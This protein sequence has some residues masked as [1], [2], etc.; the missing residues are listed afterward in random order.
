MIEGIPSRINAPAADIANEHDAVQAHVQALRPSVDALLERFAQR[1]AST[2]AAAAAAANQAD[3][4][5][6][7][8]AEG[9]DILTPFR[10]LYMQ[11]D[12]TSD[13]IIERTIVESVLERS[14][15]ALISA[16]VRLIDQLYLEA[17]LEIDERHARWLAH[18]ANSMEHTA[19]KESSIEALLGLLTRLVAHGTLNLQ[20][21]MDTFLL[22][23]LLSSVRRMTDPATRGADTAY[24]LVAIVGSLKDMF[25][26]SI[27]GD[28]SAVAT[29]SYEDMRAFG[30]QTMLLFAQVNLPSLLR[31]ATCLIC[32][33][34]NLLLAER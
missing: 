23:Y 25:A 5:A 8:P 21:A 16:A 20:L 1:L 19:H 30:A 6:A 26:S 9:S 3:N 18:L 13:E 17:S 34:M 10:N 7:T 22:P 24:H 32:A 29:V 28:S 12:A 14:S 2:A 33:R 4:N 27:G 11:P 15:T 31:T